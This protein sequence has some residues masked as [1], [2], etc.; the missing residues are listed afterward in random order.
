M[1][2]RSLEILV[3]FFVCLGIAAVFVLTMR[4]SNLAD[5]SGIEGYKVTAAFSNI[6]G[7][8]VGAPVN[9]AGVRIGRVA[10][11]R[12]NP[13]TY[14]AV[15]TMKLA[16]QYKIPADS[17]AAILTAGL[18]GSQYVGVGPGGAL[19]YLQP[20][21]EFML[22]QSAIVLEDIISQFLYSMTASDKP[23]QDGG[24]GNPGS[25]S[26]GGLQLPAPPPLPDADQGASG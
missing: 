13:K 20:G 1:Q 18:L 14:Q 11:I 21:D 3:G 24:E 4:V 23:A 2:S 10:D 12:I 9:M 15:V 17:D 16:D 26:G 7:L 19:E 8:Q 6:G 22:T 25:G 5:T